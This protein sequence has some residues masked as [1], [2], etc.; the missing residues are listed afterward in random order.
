MTKAAAVVCNSDDGHTA[1]I[2]DCQRAA[3]NDE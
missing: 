3:R 1:A 2:L